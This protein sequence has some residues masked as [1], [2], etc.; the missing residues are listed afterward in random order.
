MSSAL[1]RQDVVPMVV[2]YLLIM[3]SLAIGL[4]LVRRSARAEPDGAAAVTK[5]G[6]PAVQPD[7]APVPA[8][9]STPVA[10]PGSV[11]VPTARDTGRVTPRLTGRARLRAIAS[12]GPGWRRLVIHCLGTAVGGY[13]LLMVVIIGYYYGIAPSTGNFVPSAFSGCATLLALA[14]PVFFVLSWLVERKGWRI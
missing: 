14:A 13:L 8:P 5:P 7:P 6:R 4:R 2:G 11:P 1:I 10:V 9:V 12:P 3:G